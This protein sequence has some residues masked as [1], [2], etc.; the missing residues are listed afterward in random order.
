MLYL[1]VVVA[2]GDNHFAA[3]AAAAFDLA[4]ED[5]CAVDIGIYANMVPSGGRCSPDLVDE[6]GRSEGGLIP[7]SYT[8]RMFTAP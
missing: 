1:L 7:S 4:T 2:V 6:T 8:I 3:A 5:V